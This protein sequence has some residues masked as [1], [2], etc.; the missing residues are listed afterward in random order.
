[1]E[2]YRTGSLQ[3]FASRYISV[4]GYDTSWSQIG[5]RLLGSRIKMST[6]KLQSQCLPSRENTVLSTCSMAGKLIGHAF[7]ITWD[8]DDKGEGLHPSFLLAPRAH[9]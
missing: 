4:I 1:M 2:Y 8:Y 3:I 5:I 7:A 6:A 9:S